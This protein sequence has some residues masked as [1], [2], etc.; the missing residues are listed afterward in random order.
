MLPMPCW[1]CT[2]LTIPSWLVMMHLGDF[3]TERPELD[4]TFGYFG[5]TFRVEPNV[6]DTILLDFMTKASGIDDE[7]GPEAMSAVTD[8]LAALIHHEDFP[9]FM[10]VARANRQTIEDLMTVGYKLLESVTVRPTPAPAASSGGR[11]TTP[12]AS[13]QNS[14]ALTVREGLER[15]GRPDLALAVLQAEELRTSR[16]G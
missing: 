10:H 1:H 13:M 3:G 9:T 2:I 11:S 15:H 6:T 12:A 5:N 4:A 8:F 14:S 16:V 7:L